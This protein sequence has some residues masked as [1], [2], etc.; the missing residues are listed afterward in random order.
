MW[1]CL[2]LLSVI[3][4][5]R[6]C[7]VLLS[8]VLLTAS[9]FLLLSSRILPERERVDVSNIDSTQ[10]T[11]GKQGTA[12]QLVCRSPCPKKK[13][14]QT[15]H[16]TLPTSPMWSRC[17]C[18]SDYKW[19]RNNTKRCGPGKAVETS[20]GDWRESSANTELGMVIV[21]RQKRKWG[22]CKIYSS[23]THLSI[24][25]T[26]YMQPYYLLTLHLIHAGVW[27]C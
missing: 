8:V 11:Y 26:L 24:P 2:S 15:L 22:M 17:G 1:S 20:E 7:F 5:P 6:L 14:L 19:P 21:K 18:V 25:L 10:G 12:S 13:K 27:V 23:P 3:S 4:L 16:P 9:S